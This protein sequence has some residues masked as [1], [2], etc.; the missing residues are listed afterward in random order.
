LGVGIG[1]LERAGLGCQAKNTTL[2]SR[3][4]RGA[5][6]ANDLQRSH[7]RDRLNHTELELAAISYM[8][9][10]AQKVVPNN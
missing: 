3:S 7:D 2:F 1:Q 5:P 10:I 4:S 8:P 6:P 9:N